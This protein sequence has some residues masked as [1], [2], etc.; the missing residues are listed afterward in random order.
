MHKARRRVCKQWWNSEWRDRLFAFC[1]VLAQYRKDFLIPV[2]DR[3]SIRMALVPMTFDSPWTYFEDGVTGL[4]ETA[5]IELTEEVENG[6]E[7]DDDD[8]LD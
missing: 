7:D 3:E 6:D 8:G 2:S 1:A 4:D 5:D